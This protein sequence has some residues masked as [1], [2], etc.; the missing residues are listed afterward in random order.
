MSGSMFSAESPE[1]RARNE[2]P[3]L[4]AKVDHVRLYSNDVSYHA[5]VQVMI[6]LMQ[7]KKYC[8]EELIGAVDLA[9]ELAS[10]RAAEA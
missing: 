2:F 9:S 4:M 7:E 3:H 6:Q 5:L 8:R 1:E 10:Y